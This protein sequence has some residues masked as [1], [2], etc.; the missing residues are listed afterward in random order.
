MP[1]IKM[2][3]KCGK[4]ATHGR[5]CNYHH[6]DEQLRRK[7]KTKAA[8]YSS[9][10]WQYMRGVA[11]EA[12]GHACTRCGTRINLT[13]HLHPRLNGNHNLATLDD[14]TVLCRG[15][16]GSVDAPRAHA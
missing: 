10:H 15:C 8:G 3:S 5:H 11:L 1:V 16:H 9:P 13:V 7:V 12:A 2:C 6:V 4:P 14:C